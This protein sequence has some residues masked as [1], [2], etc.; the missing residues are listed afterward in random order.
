M[1]RPLELDTYHLL[2]S[3]KPRKTFAKAEQRAKN[4]SGMTKPHPENKKQ[5]MDLIANFAVAQKCSETVKSKSNGYLRRLFCKR[6]KNFEKSDSSEIVDF[7]VPVEDLKKPM[8]IQIDCKTGGNNT[9]NINLRLKPLK[10]DKNSIEEGLQTQTNSRLKKILS[11]LLTKEQD[12]KRQWLL[13]TKN[14][15]RPHEELSESSTTFSSGFLGT[16]AY[17]TSNGTAV[18]QTENRIKIHNEIRQRTSTL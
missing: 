4:K 15:R 5:K 10:T 6:E 14:N 13:Q 16:S 11:T 18:N 1:S 17:F 2:P 3:T 12:D 9:T 8:L 7:C